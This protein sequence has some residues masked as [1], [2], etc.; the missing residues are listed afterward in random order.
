ME[1]EKKIYFY[2]IGH[3]MVDYFE[4]K[5]SSEKL[6][7][8]KKII[9]EN[10]EN[11]VSLENKKGPFHLENSEFQ[12]IFDEISV[13][14]RVYHLGGKSGRLPRRHYRCHLLAKFYP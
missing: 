11:K 3:S 2:G 6:E 5:V 4:E 7:K 8:C 14:W 1:K 13:G 12:G 10:L 9:F